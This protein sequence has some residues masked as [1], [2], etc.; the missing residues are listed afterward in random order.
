VSRDGKLVAFIAG[1]M[2]DF[3]STGGDVYT[4]PVAGGAATDVTPGVRAS[5]LELGWS[6]GGRLRADLLAGD[7]DEIV[8]LGDGKRP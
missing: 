3:G 2:S 4:M 5:A 8:E 1:I 6:C 7:K